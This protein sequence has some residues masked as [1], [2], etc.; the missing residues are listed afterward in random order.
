MATTLRPPS[1]SPA[2]SAPAAPAYRLVRPALEP[3]V[4]PVLEASQQAGVDQP[5]GA[6][7]VLAGPGTGKTTTLVE[8]VVARVERGLHPEQVL[9]LT[10]CSKAADALRDRIASRLGP[11]V[12]YR[13]P[14]TFHSWC[15][16]LLRS[17]AEPGRLPRLL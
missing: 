17:H 13:S 16:A 8:A 11:S 9:V 10:V 6:L 3:V 5:G 4:A 7:L 2:A 12:A 1:R 15:F 14:S